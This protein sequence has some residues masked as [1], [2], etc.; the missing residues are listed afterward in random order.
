M[1]PIF[2]IFKACVPICDGDIW[3]TYKI[4]ENA[5]D[6]LPVSDEDDLPPIFMKWDTPSI[7]LCIL[8][9]QNVFVFF[10]HKFLETNMHW[11]WK[12]KFN[13]PMSSVH[14]SVYDPN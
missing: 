14:D 5:T 11:T 9:F 10:V 7:I 3:S 12:I 4:K 8:R 13:I 2:Y 6:C 1:K